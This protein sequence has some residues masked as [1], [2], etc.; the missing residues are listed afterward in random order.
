MDWVRKVR[1]GRLQIRLILCY[2][3]RLLL[4]TAGSE[5]DLI[6]FIPSEHNLHSNFLVQTPFTIESHTRTS[7]MPARRHSIRYSSSII[8]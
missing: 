2:L 4:L 7:V 8:I 5:A 3:I 1:K 6:K